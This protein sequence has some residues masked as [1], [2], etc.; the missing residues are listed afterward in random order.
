MVNRDGAVVRALASY[1]CGPGFISRCHVL[2]EFVAGYRLA[3][4][5]F[6]PEVLWFLSLDPQKPTLSNFNL[7]WRE[8]RYEN[9]L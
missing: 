6:F 2:V 4:M 8:D 3:P 7:T 1:Q 5:V 9:Q